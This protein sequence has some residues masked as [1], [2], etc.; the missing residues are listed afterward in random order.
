MY[1]H[2]SLSFTKHLITLTLKI[3]FISEY[4]NESISRPPAMDENKMYPGRLTDSPDRSLF[5]VCILFIYLTF[6]LG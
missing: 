5:H 2:D 4:F 1:K 3:L 6:N